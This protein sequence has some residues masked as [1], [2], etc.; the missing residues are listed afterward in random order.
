MALGLQLTGEKLSLP[1]LSSF[2]S[3]DPK[4]SV[5]LG[6]PSWCLPSSLP[7]TILAVL[8][9]CSALRNVMIDAEPH[10]MVLSAVAWE[11][12]DVFEG[13]I[14][15]PILPGKAHSAVIGVMALLQCEGECVLLLPQL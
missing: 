1:Q 8:F 3:R 14:C 11:E 6:R 5:F 13:R 4:L 9:L 12:Q 7:V 15:L 2:T 10:Q